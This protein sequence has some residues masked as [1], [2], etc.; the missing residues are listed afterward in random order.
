V[1]APAVVL[2]ASLLMAHAAPPPPLVNV[3]WDYGC[4]RSQRLVVPDHAWAAIR[5]LLGN[6][7]RNPAA[8]R[9]RIAIAI[10]RMEQALGARTG[11]DADLRGNFAGSGQAGQMDCIDES[12]NTTGYLHVLA[13]HDL[14]HWHD[15]GE[16]RKRAPWLF[17]QHWT[18]V[19]VDRS[20]G[21]RWAI[22]SWHRDN[23]QPPIV[24]RL[25]AWLDKD[26]PP[27]R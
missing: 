6:A 18:A 24:Q 15:V 10:A 14:L 5:D 8:E 13:E 11:T 12:R 7:A 19:L 21:E 17:D 1:T 16:R 25:D 22:D 23:G 9:D 26:A 27:D 20:D 3:C 4:D 2:G